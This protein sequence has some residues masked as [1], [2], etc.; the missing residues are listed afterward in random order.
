MAIIFNLDK[1][2]AQ[3]KMRSTELAELLGCTVQTVSRIKQGKIRAFR[4]ETVDRL[5]EIFQCQP[6]DIIEYMDDDEV[7]ERFGE[8]FLE[9]YRKYFDSDN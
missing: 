8:A 5:C 4:I 2:L 3:K 7:A 1:L 6:G 9:D